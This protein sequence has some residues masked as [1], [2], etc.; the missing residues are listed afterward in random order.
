[1]M[2]TH[3]FPTLSLKLGSPAGF[4]PPMPAYTANRDRALRQPYL[5]APDTMAGDGL[6]SVLLFRE[7]R[8]FSV[9]W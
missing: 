4:L 8:N 9:P 3:D 2:I 6:L 7:V 5:H 1:M